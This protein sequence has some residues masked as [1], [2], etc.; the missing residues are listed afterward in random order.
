ME[1]RPPLTDF[2]IKEAFTRRGR[3]AVAMYKQGVKVSEISLALSMS[4][5]GIYRFIRQDKAYEA[6]QR[7]KLKRTGINND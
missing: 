3:K 2:D 6:R 5:S 1:N 7:E 4:T